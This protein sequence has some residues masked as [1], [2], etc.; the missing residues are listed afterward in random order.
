TAESLADCYREGQSRARAYEAMVERMLSPVRSGL[1]VC[2]AFYGHPGVFVYP[3]HEA[4]RIARSEGYEA[5]M[6][7][8]ISA[9]DCLFADLGIDPGRS[10]CQS[11]EATDFL[12]NERRIDPRSSLILWQ[13]GLV[14]RVESL[15]DGLGDNRQGL[16]ILRDVLVSYY[17]PEHDAVIYEASPYVVLDSSI[18]TVPLGRLLEAELS[19]ASTLFVPPLPSRVNESMLQR[20]GIDRSNL[21]VASGC[22]EGVSSLGQR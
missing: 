10:G 15:L 19:S 9:E 2:V 22:W 20:L 21:P 14:G 11:Y 8:G 4:I 5:R 12:V 16:S 3:S 7:P 17:S 18:R 6:L 1:K 13:V